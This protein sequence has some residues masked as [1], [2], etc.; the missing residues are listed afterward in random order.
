M[1]SNIKIHFFLSWLMLHFNFLSDS[2]YILFLLSDNMF[3]ISK[4]LIINFFLYHFLHMFFIYSF[5]ILS[6]LL[7]IASSICIFNFSVVSHPV[8][9]FLPFVDFDYLNF[10]RFISLNCSVRTD[11]IFLKFAFSITFYLL[12][13]SGCLQC[14]KMEEKISKQKSDYMAN[15]IAHK[16]MNYVFEN[17]YITLVVNRK[18][19]I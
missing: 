6:Y 4:N 16:E 10:G 15:K 11:G 3:F 1:K 12:F 13:C 19:E 8:L 5:S 18:D 7:S 2:L 14:F 9:K 17:I